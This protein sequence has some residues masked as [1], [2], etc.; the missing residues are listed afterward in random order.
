MG[1]ATVF[2]NL[3]GFNFITD[4]VWA[5]RVSPFT[6]IGP[7]RYRPPPCRIDQ[8]PKLDFG[9]IS[10]NHY[11]HMD[12]KAIKTIS[13]RFPDMKWFVPKGLKNTM[14]KFAHGNEIYELIW[15]ENFTLVRDGSQI[16]IWCVP[17]QHWST[18]CIFDKDKSLWS[19][20]AVTGQEKRFYF[21]GDTGFCEEEFGKIG[22]IL[23]PF[24]LAAI[25]IGCY[26]PR[27]IVKPQ[28]INPEAAVKVHQLVRAKQSI[29]IHWG[30]YKMG[31]AE[32]YLEPKTLLAEE[33]ALAGLPADAMI[34]VEHGATW[35]ESKKKTTY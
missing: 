23:G 20:W 10:H 11:D 6:C 15:G 1:H 31:S 16:Q 5:S 4:P 19:G 21:A 24:D 22:R 33:V 9:V 25:P 7:K 13:Q 8:L 34:T 26:T 18:R 27:H 14:R 12:R 35:T 28:H 2:V 29:G 17:A 3:E 30:T 32:P